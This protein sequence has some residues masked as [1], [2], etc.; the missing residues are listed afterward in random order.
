MTDLPQDQILLS[1]LLARCVIGLNPE[2]RQRRQ[3]LL[4]QVRLAVDLRPAG[5]SDDLADSVDYCALKKRL[6]AHAEAA[7]PKLLERM[8]QEL[9]DICL[10]DPRVR[11]VTLRLDKPGALRFARSVAIEITRRQGPR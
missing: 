9:A 1:D 2:E 7:S 11:Q 8:A 3:D 4:I 10:A 6:L 5:R